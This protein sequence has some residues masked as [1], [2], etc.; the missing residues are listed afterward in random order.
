[1]RYLLLFISLSIMS[2]ATHTPL[3]ELVMFNKKDKSIESPYGNGL[4]VS[5]LESGTEKED[6]Y[7]K[8]RGD[9]YDY[10]DFG[11]PNF[12]FSYIS[13]KDDN[14]GYSGSLGR[15]VGGDFTVNLKG[16]NYLTTSVSLS[17]GGS[18]RLILQRRIL[19]KNAVGLASGIFLGMDRKGYDDFCT[20]DIACTGF[21]GPSNSASLFVT[22]ARIRMA[23]KP[24]KYQTGALSG[25]FEFGHIFEINRPYLGFSVSYVGFY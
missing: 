6:F 24:P 8:Q 3:S 23:L 14:F 21:G 15:G 4:A 18:A 5:Y 20:D 1:M 19:D 16:D 10:D 2:C 13:M 17:G 9:Y 22:G 25:S 11:T 12:T 7:Q